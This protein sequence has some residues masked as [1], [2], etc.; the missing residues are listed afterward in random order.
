M[1]R[2]VGLRIP[3]PADGR[4][5]PGH[6]H[7]HRPVAVGAA[8][9]ASL[10]F[11]EDLWVGVPVVVAGPDGQDCDARVDG[12]EEPRCVRRAAVVGDFQDLR[13]QALRTRQEAGLGGFLTVAREQQ[14]PCVVG[15]PQHQRVVVGGGAQGT[16]ARGAEDLDECVPEREALTCGDLQDRR[17][18][19]ASGSKR[20]R[21]P[22]MRAC[23]G[24]NRGGDDRADG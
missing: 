21:D 12:V 20:P 11:A 23:A 16:V 5:P 14:A 9:V 24:G 19:G 2:S 6:D 17:T 8:H 13:A 1:Q 7:A 18:A 15:D 4:L 3:F 22:G 10:E